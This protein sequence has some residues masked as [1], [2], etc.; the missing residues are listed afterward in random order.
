[1]AAGVKE[2]WDELL[3]AE[4]A[5]DKEALIA[6]QEGTVPPTVPGFHIVFGC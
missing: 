5:V 2:M 6:H 1:M 3:A 4:S